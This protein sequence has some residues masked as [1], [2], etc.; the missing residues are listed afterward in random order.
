M[1]VGGGPVCRDLSRGAKAWALPGVIMDG[2]G[3]L[4]LDGARIE[5]C[6]AGA[7]LS[8]SP[9]PPGRPIRRPPAPLRPI[10]PDRPPIGAQWR[11][12]KKT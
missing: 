1:P 8:G 2:A 3:I 12:R 11:R 5:G 7:A 4:G 6:L 10:W 9:R